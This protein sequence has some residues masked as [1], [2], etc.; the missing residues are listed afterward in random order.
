MKELK[1]LHK[2]YLTVGLNDVDLA[3]Y[4][5]LTLYFAHKAMREN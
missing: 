3:R 1:A 2:K 4:E 5:Y